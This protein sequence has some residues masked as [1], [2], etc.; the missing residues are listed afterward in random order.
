MRVTSKA[1]PSSTSTCRRLHVGS[2]G[3]DRQA[4][5][6][7]AL[8]RRHRLSFPRSGTV[9]GTLIW[10]PAKSIHFK[11]ILTSRRMTLKDEFVT[12]SK[13]EGADAMMM[14]ALSRGMGRSRSLCGVQCRVR[15]EPRRTLR[16]AGNVRPARYQR[17]RAARRAGNF[18]FSTGANEFAGSYTAGI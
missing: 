18:L 7:G 4:R 8:A 12:I 16:G 15:H 1:G 14:R 5:H 11:R 2:L 9:K 13:G 17:H 3:R 6:A 10:Q